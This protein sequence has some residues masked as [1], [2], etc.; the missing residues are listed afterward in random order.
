MFEFG[1]KGG[2]VMARTTKTKPAADEVAVDETAAAA[3]VV[4]DENMNANEEVVEKKPVTKKQS[5]VKPLEKD[6]EI[7]VIALIPNVSYKDS[8]TGDIYKWE[9]VGQVEPMSFEVVQRMWQKHKNYFKSM[10][11]KPCDDRVVKK[12]GLSGTYEKYDFLMDKSNYTKENINKIC[13][14]ISSTPSALKLSLCNR[15]KSMVA[16]GDV[17][18][19]KVIRAMENNLKIDLIS[20]ID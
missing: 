10:C 11:L 3:S 4:A 8:H 12:F 16:N 20:L 14:S 6:D 19:I 18:D 15:V 5:V 17:S 13:D 2:L 9:E 7:E 1:K